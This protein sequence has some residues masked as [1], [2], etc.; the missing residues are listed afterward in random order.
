MVKIVERDNPILRQRAQ[1]VSIEEI[2][3]PRIQKIIQDMKGALSSQDDGVAIAAP[4]I[5]VPLRIF[6]V[7]GK[8]LGFMKD[9]ESEKFD[10]QDLVFINPKITK[11]SREKEDMEEGCLSIRYLYGKV[12]RSKKVQLEALDEYGSK[13]NRGASGLMAQIFQ[14]ETDHLNGI[15]FIDS[16]RDVEDV[17]PE[18]MQLRSRKN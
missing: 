8:V 5:N 14:H 15:L 13:I 18:M 17:P 1:E 16:A 9:E 12:R 2:G 11:F 3:T 4:Q 7:S 10:H 6:V